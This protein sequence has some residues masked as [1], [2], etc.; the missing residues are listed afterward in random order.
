MPIRREYSD[1]T[2]EVIDQE[3]HKLIVEAYRDARTILTERKAE[4]TVLKDALLK[5]E[6]LDG[7][8]VKR[9]L[10]GEVIT[11][12]TVTELLAAE[13]LRARR[14]ETPRLPPSPSPASGRCR[15]G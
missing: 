9:I 12:P 5:Y 4:L 10:A 11:K 7:E 15:S 8:D 1:K 2:A 3:V 6:T 13:A 14:A